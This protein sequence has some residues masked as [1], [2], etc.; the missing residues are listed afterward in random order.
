[1]L[2]MLYPFLRN[3]AHDVRI[4]SGLHVIVLALSLLNNMQGEIYEKPTD[5]EHAIF[6]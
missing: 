4:F 1:M 2:S 3:I 5:T 6:Y